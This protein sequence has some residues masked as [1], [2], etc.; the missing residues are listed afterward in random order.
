MNNNLSPREIEVLR[1]IVN[2]CR[3]SK[4]D[5]INAFDPVTLCN[6]TDD[7]IDYLEKCGYISVESFTCV[8]LSSARHVL[9]MYDD[10]CQKNA[11]YAAEK[12]KDKERTAQQ[13]RKNFKRT[14]FITVFSNLVTL[15]FTL[16]VEHFDELV[17]FFREL[18]FV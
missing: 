14:F 9:L 13:E 10:T 2:A 12:N 5:V 8:A 3:I 18:F 7:I 16:L 6:E 17:T 4:H 11:E 15:S 1:L